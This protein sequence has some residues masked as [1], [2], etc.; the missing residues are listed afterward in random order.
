MG[1]TKS[2]SLAFMVLFLLFQA[3]TNTGYVSTATAATPTLEIAPSYYSVENFS[4]IFLL[5]LTIINVSDLYGWETQLFYPNVVECLN[6]TE[7]PFLRSSGDTFWIPPILNGEYNETHDMLY[8]ACSLLGVSAGAGGSGTLATMTFRAR[9]SGSG[10]LHLAYTQLVDT[11]LNAIAHTTRDGF[12]DVIASEPP[13]NIASGALSPLGVDYWWIHN[14]SKG[15]LVLLTVEGGFF[16]WESKLFYS[17][18]TMIQSLDKEETH[19]YDFY[20]NQTGDLLLRLRDYTFGMDYRVQCTHRVVTFPRVNLTGVEADRTIV[21]QGETVKIRVDLSN[22]EGFE[23]TIYVTTLCGPFPM[24]TIRVSSAPRARGL[25]LEFVWNT[26]HVALG[27]YPIIAEY[28]LIHPRN[29][30]NDVLARIQSTRELTITQELPTEHGEWQVTWWA[31]QQT[32]TNGWKGQ[33][34]GESTFPTTFN[35]NWQDGVVFDDRSDNICFVA[36]MTIHMDKTDPIFIQIGSD[37]GAKLFV[38]GNLVIDMWTAGPYRTKNTTLNLSTGDHFLEL[39]YFESDGWARVSFMYHPEISDDKPILDQ[40]L[41]LI[42]QHYLSFL[43]GIG[44]IQEHC[45]S[46]AKGISEIEEHYLFF[47]TGIGWFGGLGALAVFARER[48]R[49]KL[50]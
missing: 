3:I 36:I 26:T 21:S 8:F 24:Q 28:G 13:T 40:I 31:Y 42:Q 29:D 22:E 9:H 48:K 10:P 38:D 2:Y 16:S 18:L 49:N 27:D 47:A 15:D 25:T 46:F 34:I 14:V 7:G 12:V 35:F 6:I 43:S 20:A 5:D 17:N 4:V 44:E 50:K 11:E 1:K 32:G 41:S 23:G 45:L 39:W 30:R 33:K 19:T 37:D